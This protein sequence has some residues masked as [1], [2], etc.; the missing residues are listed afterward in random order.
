M[1]TIR[2]VGIRDAFFDAARVA[3]DVIAAPEVAERWEQPSALTHWSVAGLA[4]HLFRALGS[5]DAYLDRP[6]PDAEPL[7]AAQY[8]AQVL[9]AI[10]ETPSLDA[11]IR[12]RG[13][14]ASAGGHAAMLA[15][16]D[17]ATRRLEERLPALPPGRKLPAF[18]TFVLEIDQY[19]ITRIIESVVHTDDLAV[20]VGIP[21]PAIPTETTKL[22][23]G[24]LT[25][26]A[27]IRRGDLAVLRA[28]T[29]RERDGIQALRVL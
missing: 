20:S 25:E 16:Y 14:E 22:A 19:L 13:D 1:D 5:V 9:D 6:E 18:H 4:G 21:T 17:A 15:S 12:R 24:C 11:D 2:P 3:R 29:R 7:S 8:Y 28:L 26:T 23:I 27:R 10:E